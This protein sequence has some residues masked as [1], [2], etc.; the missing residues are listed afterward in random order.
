[1]D[2]TGLWPV[3]A[4]LLLNTLAALAIFIRAVL[5]GKGKR[6]TLFMLSWFIFIVP[7]FGLLYIL[8]GR[9]IGFLNRK[10]N[11]DMSDV[12]F[13]QEREKLILPPDQATEMNYVPI[14]DAMAVSDTSSL[15]K[16]V[17]DTLRNSAKKTISSIAAAMNSRDT[18]T[19]H[20]AASVILDAL[21]QCRTTAQN[22][23]AQM[24]KHPEDVEMNLLTLE[25]L[26]EILSMKIMNDIEQR[27]YIYIMNDAAENLFTHNLW[28]MSATH[29]LWMTDLF[30]SIKDYNMADQ[31]V[32]RAGQYRPQ[33]LDTYKARLHLYFEQ[34]NPAAFFDCLEE[35]REA[36]ITV[37]DEVLGLF[38][39]YGKRP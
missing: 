8:L 32:T 20:Y 17:L 21:S 29:Y 18:E 19:S 6:A 31:W 1:M 28:Y 24:Q 27:T 12:S 26:H 38:R 23:T 16:L 4:I 35:L 33:A 10:K 36:D 5:Q 2:T 3:L 9:F 25:Y 37:D 11:V 34:Q 22:M 7:L 15:R 13:S 39:L 30:I 14:Q